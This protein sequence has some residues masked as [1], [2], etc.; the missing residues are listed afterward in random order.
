MSF[1]VFNVVER[2]ERRNFSKLNKTHV[3]AKLD[4]KQK[5]LSDG[6]Q[7]GKKIAC[8]RVG[9]IIVWNS[10]STDEGMRIVHIPNHVDLWYHVQQVDT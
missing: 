10:G 6:S 7:K 5:F 9:H 3:R 4:L 2:V 8:N 1:G